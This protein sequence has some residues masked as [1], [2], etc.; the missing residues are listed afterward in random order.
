M[1]TY[2]AQKWEK[3]QHT[4]RWGDNPYNRSIV[5]SG[6]LPAAYIGRRTVMVGS[7]HGCTLLTEGFHF[8]V[9]DEEGRKY[10]NEKRRMKK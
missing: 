2:T 8:F 4:G 7:I 10:I 5:E 6:E 3:E 1:R 9:D